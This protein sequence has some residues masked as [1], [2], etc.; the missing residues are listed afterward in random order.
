MP[1]VEFAALREEFLDLLKAPELTKEE[2]RTGLGSFDRRDHR[3]AFHS[4]AADVVRLYGWS[5][6]PPMIDDMEA[7]GTPWVNVLRN[8]TGVLPVAP[9]DR[10]HIVTMAAGW[11]AWLTELEKA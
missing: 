4:F 6:V 7:T 3:K 2:K 9:T 5:A 11:R 8:I 10:L 1:A